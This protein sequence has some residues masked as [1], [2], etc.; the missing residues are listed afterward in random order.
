[1]RHV[2]VQHVPKSHIES[3]PVTKNEEAPSAK[4]APKQNRA[5]SGEKKY[6]GRSR[7]RTGDLH[8]LRKGSQP[9]IAPCV[10]GVKFGDLYSIPG[11]LDIKKAMGAEGT[12]PRGQI[13]IK[14][15]S[16]RTTSL[17]SDPR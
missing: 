14:K 6:K 3:T 7:F 17:R 11:E 5:R 8:R 13:K 2:H 1:M 15:K 12:F 16:R 4:R 10:R 9:E